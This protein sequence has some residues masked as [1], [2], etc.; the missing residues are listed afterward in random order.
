MVW[1]QHL[2]VPAQVKTSPVPQK[3]QYF[4]TTKSTNYLVNALALLDAEVENY[5]QVCSP[6]I[7]MIVF[8]PQRGCSMVPPRCVDIQP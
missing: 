1:P 8:L 7:L 4:A 6:C 3:D 5:D 2:V